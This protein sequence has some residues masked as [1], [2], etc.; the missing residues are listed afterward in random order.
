[1]QIYQAGFGQY[2]QEILNPASGLY[3]FDPQVVVL[4]IEGK[5]W[6]PELYAGYLGAPAAERDAAVARV[7]R[8][9]T[10]L[11][12]A[13]RARSNAVVLV[14]NLSAPPDPALG[15]YDIQ[16]PAGQGRTVAALNDWL[17]DQARATRGIYVVDYAALTAK[18]GLLNWY[19]D[20]MGQLAQAPIAAAQL[21][22]LVIEYMKYCRAISGLAKKCV[23]V[24]LDN[25]LWGGILGEAGVHGITLGP[26]YPGSA[27]VAFQRVLLN[28]QRRGVLLAVASKNNLADVAEVFASHPHMVLARDHF[29]AM[30]VHWNPKSESVSAIARRLNID[31][32][33]VVFVDDNP[34]ECEEVAAALPMVQTIWLRQQPEGYVRAILDEGLFDTLSYSEEDARRTELYRQREQAETAQEQ[35]G[36]LEEFYRSLEM[37]VVFAPVQ[38]QTLAR[39]TQLTQKTNQFNATTQRY[40]EADLLARMRDDSWQLTTVGVRD[41]FGDHGIVGLVMFRAA[42]GA[43]EIDTFLLSCRVIGRGIETAMLAHVCKHGLAIGAKEIRGRVVPTPKNVPVRD[44]F[45]RHRFERVD[46]HGDATEWRLELSRTQV[47]PPEWLAVTTRLKALG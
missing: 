12:D 36:S 32:E 42:G 44:V 41:R 43:V 8:E 17:A 7:R 10:A 46:G 31:L 15:I 45:E 40:S 47:Q 24:D 29:A 18:H 34:A 5:D 33:H 38:P 2:R 13:F 3:G 21:P 16:A 35:A 1:M 9:I 4:A 11:L 37:Q 28:L 22:R 26:T 30:Q 20:R 27:F 14:H 19:D 23:V 6:I 25:T 39:A